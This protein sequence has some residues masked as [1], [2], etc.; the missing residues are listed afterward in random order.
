MIF[1]GCISAAGDFELSRTGKISLSIT[2]KYCLLFCTSVPGGWS[3]A[4]VK[5]RLN[6]LVLH[7][8]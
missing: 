8:L 2:S 1:P 7:R 5:A 3:T 6:E 4:K